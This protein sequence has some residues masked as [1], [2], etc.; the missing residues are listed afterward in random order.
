MPNLKLTAS[1]PQLDRERY[2]ADFKSAVERCV[3]LA[4]RQFLLAA[5]PRIPVFTG[6]ARGSLGNLED[7]AGRVSGGK[8]QFPCRRLQA[9]ESQALVE[10]TTITLLGVGE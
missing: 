3:V 6:F 4:A 2:L 1:W 9:R 10:D 7:V 8:V 5:V